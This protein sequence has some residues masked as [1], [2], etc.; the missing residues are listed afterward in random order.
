MVKA[1]KFLLLLTGLFVAGCSSPSNSRHL[2][3]SPQSHSLSSLPKLYVSSWFAPFDITRGLQSFTE[4]A[5]DLNEINPVWYN[6]NP[7]YY[8]P[9]AEPFNTKLFQKGPIET[10]AKT[11]G[12]KLV[13]T[14]QNWGTTNFDPKVISRIINNP[15][16]RYEHVREILELVIENEY[17]GIDIDYENLPIT[18]TEGFSAFIRELGTALH[19]H[20]KLLSVALHPKTT[21]EANWSGPGA[22]DWVVMAQYADELKIMVYDFHWISYHAGPIAPLDWLRDVLEYA[23]T[24]PEDK[25]KIIIGLPLYGYDWGPEGIAKALTY[26]DTIKLMTERNVYSA[27]REHVDD[28]ED[29]CRFYTDNN[30]PHFQYQLNGATHTVYFQD[31]QAIE[32]RVAIVKEYPELVKGIDFWRLGGESPEIWTEVGKINIKGGELLASLN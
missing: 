6:L 31:V 5:N 16:D 23:A 28:S 7:S 24:I 8:Q 4:H 13:P 9:G 2:E 12:V 27:S 3:L 21:T 17:D 19:D 32:K 25:G 29:F 15:V 20:G 1:V 11:N 22:Q 26:N 14:I 18:D 30:E 10:L